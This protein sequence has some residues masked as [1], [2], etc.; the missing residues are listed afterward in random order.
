MTFR[1]RFAPSPTGPLHLGH[2]YSALLAHDAARRHGGAFLLRIEDLDQSRVRAE[3]EEL[4]YLDLKWLG[5]TWDEE[6]IKQSER[7]DAYLSVL[8]G[9]SPAI[10]TFTCT[11]NRRDIHQAMGAPHAEDMA[12]GPDGLIYPGT[13]RA[14]HYDPRYGDLDTL[15]LRLSLNLI[16]HNITSIIHSEYSDIS[17]FNHILSSMTLAEFQDRIG[18][19]V[20]WRKGYAAYHLASVMDDAHQGITHIIRGQDLME[21]TH[22]HV[23]LQTLLGVPTPAYHHHDLIRDENGKRLAKRHDAKA[24]RKYRED[25]ATPADIR[26]MVGL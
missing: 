12:F 15:N 26:R 24:I 17:F 4:I 23:L 2:A 25:G 18:E 6:P 1:T 7:K 9:K 8:A 16:Q 19:V 20:L 14:H 3:W 5:I 11:C 21:A 22:I 10:P 13:C